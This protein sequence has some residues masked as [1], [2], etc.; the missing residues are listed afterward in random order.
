MH[1]LGN[2]FV[3]FDNIKNP[4]IHQPDF[5]QRISNR[6][7]GVG[8]DQFI[9]IENTN[10]KENFKVKMYNSDG[11]ETGACGNGVRCVADYLMKKENIDKFYI[12]KLRKNRVFFQKRS[13]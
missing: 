7:I 5:V 1:G 2:D 4:T 3:I 13:D 8:C 9:I 11:S 6:R 10:I 12:C